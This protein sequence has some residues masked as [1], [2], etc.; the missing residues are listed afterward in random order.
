MLFKDSRVIG[1]GSLLVL[2]ALVVSGCATPSLAAPAP[3]AAA[4]P[5]AAEGSDATPRLLN[6]SGKGTATA[7]PD[8][9]Y[10]ELGVDVKSTS[11]S[12]AV[13][14]STDRMTKVMEA[15][16][17][18]GVEEKDI[19]T[20]A[21]NIWVEDEYDKQ[22]NPTGKRNYHVANQV[23]VTLRD[24]DQVGTLLEDALEAGANTVGGIRF[25]VEDP[26]SLQEEAR[27]KAIVD[28]RARAE[29][30]AQGLG[31]TLGEPYTIS[32]HGVAVPRAENVM[33]MEAPRAA[34]GGAPVPVSPGELSISVQISVSWSIQ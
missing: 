12:E 33:L 19:Q 26:T 2:A 17:A 28:A 32:E 34:A 24:L 11:A 21:Y 25:G 9:V 4:A 18:L 29:Q 6:V 5:Q 8:V 23:R 15:I 31:V 14:E 27:D 20:I 16:K 22:G 3:A 7:A 30:L 13:S 10:V 1:L